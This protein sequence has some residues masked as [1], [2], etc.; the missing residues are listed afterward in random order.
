M[1]KKRK[2]GDFK[3]YDP[4]TKLHILLMYLVLTLVSWNIWSLLVS[5]VMSLLIIYLLR[6]VAGSVIS[7]AVGLLSLE[8]LIGIICIIFLPTTTGLFITLKL[9]LYT[10]VSLMIMKS[11]KQGE[12][13]DGLAEGFGL[14][15]KTAKIMM[16]ILDFLPKVFREKKRGRKAQ[17]AR[18]VDPDSGNIIDRI[19]ENLLLAIPNIK[20]ALTRSERQAEAMK[21]RQYLSVLRRNS[22]YEMKLNWVDKVISFIFMMLMVGGIVLMI[23]FK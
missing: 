5:F 13:L 9:L 4:R 16:L 7:P 14:R 22:I 6:D 1:I 8:L 19:R 2:I 23:I 20:Y 11:M 18:G 17:R 3:S 10:I 12:I 21:K 15:A